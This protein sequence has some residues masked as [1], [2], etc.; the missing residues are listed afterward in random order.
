MSNLNLV[1][2]QRFVELLSNIE[3]SIAYTLLASI[4]Y[5]E[6]HRIS[7][8]DFG[9]S[10]DNISYI[11]NNKFDEITNSCSNWRELVW[12]DKR[13]NLK[14]GKFIKMLYGESFPINQPKDKPTPKP[15][16]DI[17]SFVNKFKS[18]RDKN[19]NYNNFEIVTGKDIRYWYS[20]ENYSRFANS[21]TA[22]GKSCMRY[23][24][25]GNYLNMYVKNPEIFSMLIL[26]DIHGKLKGRAIIW[27][28]NL[29]EGRIL[30][31][32]IY[33]ANDS[34][35][36]S[37][38]AYAKDN[39]WLYRLQQCYGWFNKIVDPKNDTIYDSKDMLLEVKLNKK[40]EID[41][42]YYPYLDT[43]SIYNKKTF[44]LSNNGE[45]RKKKNHI[46]LVDY[47]GR[48]Q[49]EVDE[50]ERVYSEIYQDDI[51]EEDA[52]Y[53]EIDESWVYQ[54]DAVYVHNSGGKYAYKNSSKI[55]SSS[56]PNKDKKYFLKEDAIFS[57]YLNTYL[58]KDS[59]REAYMKSDKTQKVLIHYRMIGTNFVKT[60]DGIFYD[61]SFTE[62]KRIKKMSNDSNDSHYITMDYVNSMVDAIS[63]D[64]SDEVHLEEP[65]RRSRWNP[66]D[67]YE[68][69]SRIHRNMSNPIQSRLTV[70]RNS[71]SD[72][73]DTVLSDTPTIEQ[74]LSRNVIIDT[75]PHPLR[76]YE[77]MI[78]YI[79]NSYGIPLSSIES[80]DTNDNSS[81]V[82]E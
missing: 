77:N 39:G 64:N 23:A 68:G 30:M 10:N 40:P 44:I 58:Y 48:Y 17:E 1:A 24:E 25:S 76:G 8:L 35:I 47:Q 4:Q 6:S 59:V 20:Q 50:R 36:E 22:L 71:F 2:S 19:I 34:D 3:H 74:V 69:Q 27:N 51:L 31:D 5:R 21:E 78:G 43:L 42:D 28:L 32:R 12:T 53:V 9:S 52:R 62:K 57:V 16:N 56:I 82:S 45:L 81:V 26:K 79:N 66:Y 67:T 49:S 63:V 65:D 13:T 41:Y 14:I 72:V 75:M 70:N 54:N 15:E 61:K 46:I 80:T 18:E 73:H 33:C 55:V 11:I 7:Y 29:P 38:K 37:F 60:S